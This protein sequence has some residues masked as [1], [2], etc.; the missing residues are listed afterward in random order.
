MKS[1]LL[2]GIGRFGKHIAKTLYDLD[3]EIMA[4]DQNEERINEVLPFV[5]SARIGNA[6]NEEFLRSLGI[7]NYDAC[8]VGIGNHFQSALEITSLLKE[9]GAKK[10]VSRASRDVEKKFLLR[11]GADEVVYPQKQMAI[12]TAIRYSNDH[13]LDY[14]ALDSDFNVYEIDIPD[15]WLGKTVGQLNIRRE[16]HLNILA[17]KEGGKM[18]PAVTPDTLLDQGKTLLVLGKYEQVERCFR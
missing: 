2:I 3:F 13:I 15:A 10:V 17:I 7:N 16:Y 5:T 14:V 4:V 8:I 18:N 11:N 12:W 9:L 6:T 1:F